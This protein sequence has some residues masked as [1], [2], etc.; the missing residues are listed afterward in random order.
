MLLGYNTNGLA[1]H[2]VFEG[3]ALLAEIGY[4]SVAITLDHAALNP[5][6]TDVRARVDAMRRLLDDLALRSVVETGARFLLDPRHKHEPTLVTA[7]PASRGRRIDF[8][9][10]A[11]DVAATLGSDCV[12]FWS[13]VLGDDADEKAVFSRLVEALRPVAE[14]AASRGVKL[15]FEPEPGMFIDT[16]DRYDELLER[17]DVG[18]L[19]LTLDIGH[20]HCQGET[21]LADYIARYAPRLLNVHIEDMR[22]GVHEHLMFGEGEIDFPDV[23][24]ALAK[25]GYSGG[26]HVELSRHSHIAPEAARRAFEFVR[27]LLPN[28]K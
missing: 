28:C 19:G 1:H 13:G 14:H 3:V 4:K 2:D 22:S 5:Y 6:A 9:H 23:I 18:Q 27:P 26:L 21:P 12:S 25:A 17:L 7:E 10:R 8:L 24:D 11:I 15:G 20:L 16:M